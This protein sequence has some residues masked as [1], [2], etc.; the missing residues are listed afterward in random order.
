MTDLGYQIGNID[1]TVILQRPKLS[2]HKQAMKENLAELLR[3]DISCVNIKGKT[4]ERV[5]SIGE[6]RAIACHV[7]TLLSRQ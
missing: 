5:D 7:V 3:C 1:I 2:S 4:H 6:G